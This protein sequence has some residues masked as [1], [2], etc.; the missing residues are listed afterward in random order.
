MSHVLIVND[1]F[2][3]FRPEMDFGPSWDAES[4]SPVRHGVPS[5]DTVARSDFVV[6][7]GSLN[8]SDRATQLGGAIQLAVQRGT[9]AV[10]MFP[11]RMERSDYVLLEQISP[12]LASF[13]NSTEGRVAPAHPAF[14]EYFGAY[15][16]SATRFN[17]VPSEAE[18]LGRLTEEPAAVGLSVG[19]GALYLL[20]YHVAS[21]ETSHNP[22]VQAVLSS[23]TS[24][25]AGDATNLPEFLQGIRLP[26]EDAVL[27]R[28]SNL[29]RD[30]AAQRRKADQLRSYRQIV[31]RA[32]GDVLESLVI[33]VLN[34]ILNGTDA[35]AEDREDIG[36]ED[37]WL[38]SKD[39]DIALAEA[40]GIRAHVNRPGVNQV[41]NHRAHHEADVESL[42]GLL[43]VNVFRQSDDL[44]ERQTPV[45]DDVIRHAV[46]LNVLVLRTWD[47][48][49]LLMRK[50]DG[51]D[52][53]IILLEA[54]ESGGGWLEV[55][56]T[57]Q[58]LHS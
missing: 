7:I 41:D 38:V 48:F 25:R 43:I 4:L 42:P 26:G 16:I 40:K 39:G 29:E 5:P 52:A 51:D 1:N 8:S 32:S 17:S 11:V 30:I 45:S 53:G 31:G 10:C 21:V 15:G 27:D 47:P 37:F 3:H 22:L 14:A 24:H 58:E 49:S 56:E 19:R 2:G 54:I 18:V 6:V 13:T 50:L 23:V 57:S 33:E 44:A 28:I 20:P 35:S 34:R 36:A 12:A 9:V 46:R 55:K